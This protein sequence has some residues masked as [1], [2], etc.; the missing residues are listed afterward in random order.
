[1]E[2]YSV[3]DIA[4]ATGVRVSQVTDRVLRSGVPTAR[5]YVGE[6]D[7]VALVRS[8]VAGEARSRTR[9]FVSNPWSLASRYLLRG[10]FL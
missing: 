1:M 4:A 3:R 8:I 9:R 7:A 5:G 2:I 10:S 6:A